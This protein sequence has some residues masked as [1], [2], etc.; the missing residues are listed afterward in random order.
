MRDARGR[1]IN[2]GAR[3]H[4]AP[5]WATTFYAAKAPCKA[6]SAAPE[7]ARLWSRLGAKELTKDGVDCAGGTGC[8]GA[9]LKCFG[10]A[11]CHRHG[12]DNCCCRRNGGVKPSSQAWA[13]RKTQKCGCEAHPDSSGAKA[14][15][16]EKPSPRLPRLEPKRAQCQPQK[17]G[18]VFRKPRPTAPTG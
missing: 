3:A 17:R 16:L 4:S 13:E 12:A 10:P 7:A 5:W 6:R 8:D 18:S 2:V 9:Y 15:N 14:T 1:G 11:R